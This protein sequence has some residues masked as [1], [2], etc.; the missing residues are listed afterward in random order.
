LFRG[1]EQSRKEA[2][3]VYVSTGTGTKAR[4]AGRS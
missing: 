3:G 4:R 2:Q 1:K